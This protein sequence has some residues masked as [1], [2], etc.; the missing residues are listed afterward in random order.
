MPVY[1]YK[2]K[3]VS[4]AALDGIVDAASPEAA[5]AFLM[6]KKLTV[7]DISLQPKIDFV[8]LVNLFLSKKVPIKELVV[9][10]RQMAV[11]LD[12]NLPLVR[13][14]RILV[15]QTKSEYFRSVIVGIADEVDGGSALSVAMEFYSDV[16]SKFFVNIVRSGETSGRLSEVMN[17]LADQKEKDYDL[18]A[19]IKGMMMYPAMI[20]AVLIIVGFIIMAYV[21]PNIATVLTESGA[22]LPLITRL[23]IGT[24]DFIRT[25]WWLIALAAAVAAGA[26]MWGV[27]TPGG[28]ALIDRLKL[29]IPIF[30]LVYRHIYIV[31]ICRSFATLVKGG[32]PIAV[33]LAVV[34]EVVDNAVYEGVLTDASRSVDEGNQISESFMASPDVP[35]IVSQMISVGEESGKLEEILDRIADFY[36]REIDNTVRNLSNLIEP[37]IMIVLGIA[38][39]VFVAAVLLPM[40]QLS[41]SF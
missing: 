29:N 9:F 38:V 22:E 30:G 3:D 5:A 28:K 32:V 6:D 15:K 19:R 33:S 4:G 39:G 40:W 20:I 2:A 18:E 23:L 17:Y 36:S 10:F 37:I 11:M 41:S 25:F 27:K 8:R 34:R 35:A 26:I 21:V 12:A 16:F 7:L 31:R 14:L 13:A 24:S 1:Y